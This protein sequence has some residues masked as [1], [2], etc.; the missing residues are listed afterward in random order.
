MCHCPIAKNVSLSDVSYEPSLPIL[1]LRSTWETASPTPLPD[2]TW[3]FIKTLLVH[4]FHEW[5]RSQFIRTMRAVM[6][7]KGWGRLIHWSPWAWFCDT[8]EA[9]STRVPC[10]VPLP[11]SHEMARVLIYL[12]PTKQPTKFCICKYKLNFQLISIVFLANNQT[13]W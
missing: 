13:D 1:W 6:L 10:E 4:L 5:S 3:V 12:L 2:M 9:T 7:G 8:P 11:K